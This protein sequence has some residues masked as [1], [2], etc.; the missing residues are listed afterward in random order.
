MDKVTEMFHDVSIRYRAFEIGV[1][2]KET[3][4]AKNILLILL[5]SSLNSFPKAFSE[6]QDFNDLINLLICIFGIQ[7][8]TR[9]D[10]SGTQFSNLQR[11]RELLLDKIFKRAQVM[12]LS[13]PLSQFI[14]D[15]ES[16]ISKFLTV[17]IADSPSTEVFVNSLALI[18]N[19]SMKYGIFV[20]NIDQHKNISSENFD[21]SETLILNSLFLENYNAHKPDYIHM[22]NPSD[23]YTHMESFQIPRKNSSGHE[24][25]VNIRDIADDESIHGFM[26][27]LENKKF[28]IDTT[29]SYIKETLERL[30]WERQII[31]ESDTSRILSTRYGAKSKKTLRKVYSDMILWDKV[32]AGSSQGDARKHIC[33]LTPYTLCEKRQEGS[34]APCEGCRKEIS[35]SYSKTDEEIRAFAKKFQ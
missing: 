7:I 12:T 16:V 27:E 28:S 8:G 34:T 14:D 2:Y 9:N 11:S 30:I 6:K 10:S 19:V 33:D 18:Y 17:I 26:I 35:R 29:I 1:C 3:M 5:K 24:D 20:C 22:I 4:S 32:H 15:L 31:N 25:K 23:I 21:S 13:H